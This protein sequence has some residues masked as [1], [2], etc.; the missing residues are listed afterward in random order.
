M[1]RDGRLAARRAAE[2]FAKKVGGRVAAR[3]FLRPVNLQVLPLITLAMRTTLLNSLTI[4]RATG[5]IGLE[6]GLPSGISIAAANVV[7]S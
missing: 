3:P 7:T 5:L 4:C 6:Q 1:I 2:F